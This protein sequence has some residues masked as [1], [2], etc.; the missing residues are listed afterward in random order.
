MNIG[1]K[2]DPKDSSVGYAL[3]LNIGEDEFGITPQII[4]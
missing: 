4:Y 3:H 2:K 1:F